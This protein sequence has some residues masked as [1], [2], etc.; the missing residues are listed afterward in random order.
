MVTVSL[1]NSYQSNCEKR[2]VGDHLEK[3]EFVE[4]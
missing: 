2:E 1:E 4:W 3:E